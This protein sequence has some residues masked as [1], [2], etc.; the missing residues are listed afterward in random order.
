M[1]DCF[2][3]MVCRNL[4]IVLELI[5]SIGR[6]FTIDFLFEIHV[7]LCRIPEPVWESFISFYFR[8]LFLRLV[9]KLVDETDLI[10]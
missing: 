2:E 1:Q 8:F 3:I 4:E 9:F 5:I 7:H 10:L 6:V